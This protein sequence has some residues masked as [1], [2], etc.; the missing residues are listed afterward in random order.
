MSFLGC[1]CITN[2]SALGFVASIIL[3]IITAGLRFMAIITVTPAF[4]WTVFGIAVVYLLATFAV[5]IGSNNVPGCICSGLPALLT[6][7]LGTILTAVILLAVTFAATSV[8]G[9]ILTGALVLF[10]SL[11]I[12]STACLVKCASDCR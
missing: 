6:G 5:F 12:T 9:A 4:A 7:I 1:D 10:F 11:I 3:G 8:V 2:C